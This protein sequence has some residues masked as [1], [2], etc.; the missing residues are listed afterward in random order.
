[1]RLIWRSLLWLVCA[2]IVAGLLVLMGIRIER[3][4]LRGRAEALMADMQSITLRHTTFQQ[5]QPI[6]VRW[7]RWGKFV[8]PCSPARCEFDIRLH[9][10]DSRP[11]RY[12]YRDRAIFDLASLVG[13]SPTAISARIGV[14]NGVVSSEQI[15]FAIETPGHLLSAQAASSAH[16][17]LPAAAGATTHAEYAVWSPPNFPDMVRLEFTPSADPSQIHRLMAIDFSCLTRWHPCQSRNQIMPAAMR[18]TAP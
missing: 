9:G 18:A 4:I 11:D 16:I 3:R 6:F 14:L 8:R 1:M 13:E 12:L 5:V 10:L 7:R 15:G 17:D 2:G